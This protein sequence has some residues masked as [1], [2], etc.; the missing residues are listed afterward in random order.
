MSIKG[1][2]HDKEKDDWF[3]LPPEPL[4]WVI[5]VLMHGAKK[6]APDNW[7]YVKP[8][9]RYYS[10]APRHLTS[11]KDG[12]RIDRESGLPTLAHAICCLIFL[13]WHDLKGK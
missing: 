6:Y 3:L 8:K 5:R 2:K 10:A 11:W 1:V 13:L 12:E 4:R 7:V 9:E